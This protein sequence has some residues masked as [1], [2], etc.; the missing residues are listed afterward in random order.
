GIHLISGAFEVRDLV[1][2]G[3]NPGD[4]PFLTAK[5]ITVYLPWW[6]IFTHELIVDTVEMSDWDMRV[7]QF[8]GGRHNFPRVAGPKAAKRK[9]PSRS[10]FTT[11]VRQVIARRGHFLYEDHSTPWR[12]DCPNLDV[13]VF[14]GLDTYRGTAEFSKGSVKIQNYEQFPAD[15]E[16]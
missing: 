2:D 13:S 15:M 5:K 12:V 11:T 6:T 7:E 3:L 10:P 9:E 1:I 8:P 14:K 16:T 4:R